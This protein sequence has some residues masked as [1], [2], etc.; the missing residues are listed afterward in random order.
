MASAFAF[1]DP[2]PSFFNCSKQETNAFTP[3][4]IKN[5]H[6]MSGTMIAYGATMTHLIVPN[7]LGGKSDVILGWDDLT[8]YCRN[9]EHTYFGAT[10]GRI[11]N[12]IKKCEFPLS[13]RVYKVSCNEKGDAKGQNGYD[14]LHGGVLG[15]DRRVW[16][17]TAQS[18]S[19]VTWSYHSPDGEMGF[20]G[21]LHIN[22]TH[23]ITEENEW[24]IEYRGST[25]TETVVAMT[26]HAYFNLN[27]NVNNTPTVMEHV[28][29]LP[30][31]GKLQEV[32]GPPG[33]HSIA[34]G[35][36]KTV[37]P[38]SPWDFSQPKPL[39]RD[40]D[41]GTVTSKGGYDNAWLLSDWTPGM[42]ARPVLTISS[43]LTGIELTMA[44]DQPSVQIYSGNFL[45]GTDS[46]PTS[47]SFHLQR[48]K[49]Q[50]FG[51]G[52]QYYHYRGAFTLEAQQY[53]DAVNHPNF[54]SVRITKSKGY[55]QH[56]SYKFR[57]HRPLHPS[58]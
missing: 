9:H 4:V 41:R 29:T 13:G 32:T 37:S 8:Q 48:K 17:V 42:A 7:Y 1:A 5:S 36:V 40:I 2:S 15:F 10:I 33:Y 57:V 49:S 16:S 43:Q 12:R 38:G 35:K 58:V 6:G 55:S 53:I 3:V 39:G 11:A 28:L 56:T 44:T 14:T 25:T 30:H 19:S 31:G 23:S 20:P 45:N 50:T 24:T 21:D 27:A 47:P 26:N 22:V 51:S 46:D 34:T 52:S 18:S 54:P